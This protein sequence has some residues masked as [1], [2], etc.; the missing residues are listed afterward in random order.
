[1][2]RVQVGSFADPANARPLLER[3]KGAYPGSKIV[4]VDLPEGRRYRVYAGQFQTEAAAEQAAAHPERAL[5]PILSS[6]AT[7]FR[8]RLRGILEGCRSMANGL[9]D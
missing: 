3:L 8:E 5:E 4:G 1:M 9:N 6:S 7:T 2:L